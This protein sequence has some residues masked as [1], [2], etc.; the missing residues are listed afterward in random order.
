MMDASSAIAIATRSGV[1]SLRH[2]AA[3]YLWVQRE[4]ESNSFSVEKVAGPRNPADLGTKHVD[5][6]LQGLRRPEGSSLGP[7]GG[8]GGEEHGEQHL[9]G[10]DA[11]ASDKEAQHPESVDDREHPG[12]SEGLRDAAAGQLRHEHSEARDAEVPLLRDG[13]RVL[14]RA[15]DSWLRFRVGGCSGDG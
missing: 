1:D 7:A 14:L 6:V 9:H 10:S 8:T 15:G 5:G 4:V 3:R 13:D 11:P 12:D 2:L